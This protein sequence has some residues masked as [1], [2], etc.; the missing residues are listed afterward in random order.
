M[1]SEKITRTI[2]RL[3]SAFLTL[4]EA[5]N[6]WIQAK[7]DRLDCEA[8][9][10]EIIQS[11]GIHKFD[12]RDLVKAKATISGV[13]AI[14]LLDLLSLH[15]IGEFL[16]ITFMHIEDGFVLTILSSG[17]AI[18]ILLGELLIATIFEQ[19]RQEALEEQRDVKKSVSF[20]ILG[21]MAVVMPLLFVANFATTQSELIK[22]P[23]GFL[24]M[25]AL[26]AL[27][28]ALHW[29][30]LSSG[31]KIEWSRHLLSVQKKNQHWRRQINI[32]LAQERTHQS[33]LDAA[34]GECRQAYQRLKRFCAES[35]QTW[36]D[37][38]GADDLVL[39][40]KYVGGSSDSGNDN[41]SP[42]THTRQR[43]I[44]IRSDG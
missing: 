37:S 1:D 20:W 40:N 13:F 32:K 31:K 7:D 9:A 3:N 6:Q 24:L 30:V 10:T 43:R 41:P 21:L 42:P 22:T 15:P 4:K 33:K 16:L 17:V 38:L 39:F 35:T 18:L 29:T 27:V 28:A 14:A 5:C 44:P 8:E 23:F 2:E 26:G 34:S 12:E 19:D 36:R 11:S 25:L